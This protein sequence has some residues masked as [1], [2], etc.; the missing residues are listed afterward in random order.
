MPNILEQILAICA[1]RY[2]CDFRPTQQFRRIK[3][4]AARDAK[5]LNEILDDYIRQ[6][7]ADPTY[8]KARLRAAKRML[9]VEGNEQ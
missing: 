4:I 7:E 5:M 3:F 2:S 1:D 6:N 8:R 9:D